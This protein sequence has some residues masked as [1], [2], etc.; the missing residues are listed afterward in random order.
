MLSIDGTINRY[1]IAM[2]LWFLS[3]KITPILWADSLVFRIYK[4]AC[5]TVVQIHLCPP[6]FKTY[7]AKNFFRKKKT[8]CVL[9]LVFRSELVLS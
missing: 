9:L 3:T 8:N 6:N 4:F 7:T 2:F 5:K 1:Q